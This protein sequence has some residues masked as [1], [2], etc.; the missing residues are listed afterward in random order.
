MFDKEILSIFE[1]KDENRKPHDGE[2]EMCL[3]SRCA[4]AFYEMNDH[5]IERVYAYQFEKEPCSICN[6]PYGYDF[7]VW[8]VS[9]IK[10][11]KSHI[12]RE[13]TIWVW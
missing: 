12:C 7:Y 6:Y 9:N 5:G 13:V 11:T 8:P 2:M 10:T 4:S 3:C 1:G